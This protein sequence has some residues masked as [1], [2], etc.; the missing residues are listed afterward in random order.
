MAKVTLTDE[1]L[2]DFL[3]EWFG[4]ENGYAPLTDYVAVVMLENNLQLHHKEGERIWRKLIKDGIIEPDKKGNGWYS[5]SDKGMSLLRKHGTYSNYVNQGE[6]ANKRKE[7]VERDDRRVK[8]IGIL[9]TLG[10]SLLTL[11]L[12][13]CPI[14]KDKQPTKTEEGIQSVERKL[15]SILKVLPQSKAGK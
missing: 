1:Q 9:A 2:I 11:I 6:Q 3:L 14:P 12:T 10:V 7:K 13:Q 8:N 4:E 5:L 15:D